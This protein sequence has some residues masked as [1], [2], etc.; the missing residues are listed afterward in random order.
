MR[1]TTQVVRFAVSLGSGELKWTAN[2]G[3]VSPMWVAGGSVFL[4]SDQNELVRLDA[5][6]GRRIWGT[7]LPLFVKS[8]IKKR[9]KIFAHFGPV[10]AGGRLL[11]ASSDGVIRSFNPEN[12][13]QV[14]SFPLSGGAASNP[15]VAGRTLYV[16]TAKGKLVAYR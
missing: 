7:K 11:L 15:V 12:G 6:N 16:V 8:K 4:M 10:L 13:A 1:R 5:S 14:A 2:E 9:K 3:S